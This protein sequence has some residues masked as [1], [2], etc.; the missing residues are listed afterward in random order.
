M[1]NTFK[2]PLKPTAKSIPP[3]L[4]TS[5]AKS[6]QCPTSATKLQLQI[7]REVFNNQ[8]YKNV[9]SRMLSKNTIE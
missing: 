6:K 3:R 8:I 5:K 4:H 7:K 2:S 9:L 1:L